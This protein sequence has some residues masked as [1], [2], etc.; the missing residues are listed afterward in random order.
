MSSKNIQRIKQINQRNDQPFN[1]QHPFDTIPLGV[2]GLLVDMMS[3]LDLE[4]DLKI[5]SNHYVEINQ[6]N[7]YDTIITQY[8]FSQ[9]RV[10]INNGVT[11]IR[12]IEQMQAANKV[13]HKVVINIA[14]T[15][16]IKY[17]SFN[18]NEAAIGPLQQEI[19]Q[20]GLDVLPNDTYILTE[21]M[22]QTIDNTTLINM[23]L[24]QKAKQGQ[25]YYQ[26]IHQKSVLITKNDFD[27]YIIDEQV[28]LISFEGGM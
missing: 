1:S 25:E 2:D 26:K 28:D 5:G 14:G 17:L 16:S 11:T 9:S 18:G 24:Y 23:T 20:Y 21:E 19:N 7:E 4:E 6:I 13:T 22:E 12:S 8:Y 3:N 10:I 15:S 27:N